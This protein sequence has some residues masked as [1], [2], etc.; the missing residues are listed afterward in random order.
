L[1][2]LGFGTWS[3]FH[4]EHDALLAHHAQQGIEGHGESGIPQGV[5]GQVE[6]QAGA[7]QLIAFPMG[8]I[9]VFKVVVVPGLVCGDGDGDAIE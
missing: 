8:G 6:L 3:E 4:L 2:D 5:A 1:S 7:A 9:P